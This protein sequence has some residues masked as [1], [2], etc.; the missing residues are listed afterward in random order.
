MNLLYFNLYYYFFIW[1]C[2]SMICSVLWFSFPGL[3][4]I[5]STRTSRRF[6]IM[7]LTPEMEKM[8]YFLCSEVKFGTQKRYQEWFQRQVSPIA[9]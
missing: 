4:Q 7:R 6:F 5:L 1:Y 3:M 9:S 2:F 8:I